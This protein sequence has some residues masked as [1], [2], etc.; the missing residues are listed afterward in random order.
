MRNFL[1]AWKY[2]M[3]N[4]PKILSLHIRAFLRRLHPND[5]KL[6]SEDIEAPPIKDNSEQELHINLHN[7]YPDTIAAQ[8]LIW[9]IETSTDPDVL[10]NAIGMIHHIEWPTDVLRNAIG[11]I[12]HIEWP[13]TL[14]FSKVTDW[15]HVPSRQYNYHDTQDLSTFLMC[16][17]AHTLLGWKEGRLGRTIIPPILSS[18]LDATEQWHYTTLL[19]WEALQA[20]QISPNGLLLTIDSAPL[21]FDLEWLAQMLLYLIWDRR[22]GSWKLGNHHFIILGK[23]LESD[24]AIAA[25]AIL[26]IAI[27]CKVRV[28]ERDLSKLSK[29]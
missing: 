8:A 27:Y 10:R 23:C 13:T 7:D 29:M 1:T 25:N 19:I 4:F 14:T 18:S 21:T 16:R 2:Y 6:E 3:S 20:S 15:L 11:M 17:K 26:S 22:H 9:L 28:E 24:P 12:H 5:G